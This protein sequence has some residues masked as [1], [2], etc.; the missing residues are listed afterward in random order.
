M[1]TKSM[2]LEKH[3]ILY[4][5][6]F[7]IS[8]FVIG[9]VFD[10]TTFY[11]LIFITLFLT[12]LVLI[13]VFYNRFTWLLFM[14]L[15]F[16]SI[17]VLAHIRVTN[18]DLLN[19]VLYGYPNR[20]LGLYALLIFL[21]AVYVA[22]YETESFEFFSFLIVIN[23]LFVSIFICFSS[24]V[25]NLP[26]FFTQFRYPLGGAINSNIVSLYLLIGF[27]SSFYL[28]FNYRFKHT[29]YRLVLISSSLFTL[30]AILLLGNAFPILLMVFSLIFFFL[31]GLL[32]RKH[33][34]LLRVLTLSLTPLFLVVFTFAF[35]F[36]NLRKFTADLSTAERQDLFKIGVEYLLNHPLNF[37][38]PDSAADLELGQIYRPNG[39]TVIDNFHN[40]WL[41]IGLT[42]GFLVSI[43][44]LSLV[45][46]LLLYFLN[47]QFKFEENWRLR[48]T[49]SILVLSVYFSSFVTILHPMTVL[50]IGFI[51]GALINEITTN[52]FKY[53]NQECFKM[54]KFSRTLNILSLIKSRNFFKQLP[55]RILLITILTLQIYFIGKSVVI[56][57]QYQKV[58]R[59]LFRDP[60]LFQEKI[61]TLNLL[62]TK[63]NDRRYLVYTSRQLAN[64]YV[65]QTQ[66]PLKQSGQTDFTSSLACELIKE[67]IAHQEALGFQ[68]R[69][70]SLIKA[71]ASS[72]CN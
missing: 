8:T 1:K 51:L 15:I 10:G 43:L 5:I 62:A 59:S 35:Y 21:L 65:A 54:L 37:R 56:S 67:N 64:V 50:A 2:T 45:T 17:L 47:L 34:L 6:F 26:L 38:F 69:D 72:N 13:D 4:F 40:V 14:K 28:I 46:L 63:S 36:V 55:S 71:W 9:P 16:W 30:V 31:S 32:T 49:K 3:Q 12:T 27:L 33:Q 53:N 60:S 61:S 22:M 57:S 68:D 18:T 42:Y 41:E 25:S 52:R 11:K 7:T 20:N 58:E 23:T 66:I 44:L 29:L 39:N 70:S 24:I 48:A 19:R